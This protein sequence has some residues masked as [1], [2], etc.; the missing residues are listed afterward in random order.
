MKKENLI[1]YMFRLWDIR[2]QM[3]RHKKDTRCINQKINN[4]ELAVRYFVLEDK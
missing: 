2:G 1:P 4:I 3:Q